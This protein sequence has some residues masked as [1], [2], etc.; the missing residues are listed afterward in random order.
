MNARATGSVFA[1]LLW[2]LF[3]TG[4]GITDAP[5]PDPDR[6]INMSVVAGGEQVGLPNSQHHD[7]NRVA[8]S[9]HAD[10]TFG[11]DCRRTNCHHR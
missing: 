2:L 8:A 10:N 3:V 11:C 6:F 9:D 4:C 5:P 7:R 1:V